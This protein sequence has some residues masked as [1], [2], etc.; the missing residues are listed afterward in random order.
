[1]IERLKKL[2]QKLTPKN[3]VDGKCP[4]CGTKVPRDEPFWCYFCK[5]A[6]N[7]PK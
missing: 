2:I 5:Q 4:N 6:L 3:L 1:M 7:Y